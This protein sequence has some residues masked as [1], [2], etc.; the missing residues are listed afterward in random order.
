[1]SSWKYQFSYKPWSQASWAQ[2]VFSW[3]FAKAA[4]IKVRLRVVAWNSILD[5]N[6]SLLPFFSALW[7]AISTQAVRLKYNIYLLYFFLATRFVTWGTL[8]LLIMN[9]TGFI[10]VFECWRKYASWEGSPFATSIPYWYKRWLKLV[11]L[12]EMLCDKKTNVAQRN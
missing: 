4:R 6:W 7:F 1:M 2:P 10:F 9:V 5:S 3:I 8:L 11:F 12:Q